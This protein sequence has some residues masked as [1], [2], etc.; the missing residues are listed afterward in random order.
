MP[1]HGPSLLRSSSQLALTSHRDGGI[2]GV[3]EI[4]RVAGRALV[5][6]TEVHA[7]VARAH[8][9][10]SEPKM[11]RDRF[12]YLERNGFSNRHREAVAVELPAK[13]RSR[14][15]LPARASCSGTASHLPRLKDLDGLDTRFLAPAAGFALGQRTASHPFGVAAG[16]DALG[17]ELAWRMCGEVDHDAVR[18][19][20]ARA[21]AFVHLAGGIGGLELDPHDYSVMK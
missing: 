21:A 2:N 7:I 5:P 20:A 14:T 6:I 18:V 9:A 12:R 13:P 3:F 1:D 4:D 17:P 16:R 8:L 10:Q 15:G 11:S 19:D